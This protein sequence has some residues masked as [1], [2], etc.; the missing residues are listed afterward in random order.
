MSRSVGCMA[1]TAP[2]T[3]DRELPSSRSQPSSSSSPLAC[4]YAR[5]LPAGQ[6][7]RPPARPPP[8]WPSARRRSPVSSLQA[9]AAA[10]KAVHVWLIVLENRE[11]QAL[12]GS[13]QAPYFNGLA[14]Q[15]G[16]ATNY[17]ATGHPSQPNYVSL[18]AG[19]T[20][21]VT[22]DSN[23]RLNRPSLF[24]QLSAAGL[25]WRVY[26]QDLP[27]PC[28]LGSRG[29]G[30]LDGPGLPGEYARKHN[31]AISFTS[32]A[33]HPVECAKIQPLAAFDPSAGTYEM[34]VP[35][36][37]N[38][39]HNGTIAQGDA[40]LATLVPQI[41]ASPAF[42]AGGILFITFDEGTT[43]DGQLG[44][45]G[46]HV[47]TL[48]IARAVPAGYRTAAYADHWSLLHTTENLLGL[49]CLGTACE[50]PALSGQLP[51]PYGSCDKQT[52]WPPHGAQ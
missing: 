32:V 31:P 44:D 48:L 40:F 13:P 25:P 22:A 24:S 17:Y 49:P 29:G 42:S 2:G 52:V 27:S 30:G 20:S 7:R 28:F 19:S 45:F 21:G 4:G 51:S 11:Y 43:K 9:S 1:R 15:Y 41:I 47:V 38:D 16:L 3:G 46:G 6:A 18:V 5:A 33:D 26:A 35:N 39:M 10:T 8:S 23:Y 34:I 14:S 12:L 50:H 36:L 37:V